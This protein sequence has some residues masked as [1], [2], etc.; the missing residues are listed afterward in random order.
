MLERFV[1]RLDWKVMAVA[2]VVGFVVSALIVAGFTWLGAGRAVPILVGVVALVG[3]PICS[4]L[5]APS[6]LVRVMTERNLRDRPGQVSRG[7]I[8]L[9][10]AVM[11]AGAWSCAILIFGTPPAR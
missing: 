9:T 5:V 2:A 3:G 10:F 4:A 7:E 6:E 8:F 1:A 11:T